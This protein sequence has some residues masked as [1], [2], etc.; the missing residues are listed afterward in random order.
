VS[1]TGRIPSM[2]R[3]LP[4]LLASVLVA[5][6]G[7][8][9]PVASPAPVPSGPAVVADLEFL[10]GT[11]QAEDGTME[12]WVRGG[13]CLWGVG[14]SAQGFEALL[15]DEKAGVPTYTA[16]PEG[17]TTADFTLTRRTA[18]SATFSNPAHDFPKEIEYVR[19]GETLVATVRGD[20]EAQSVTLRLMPPASAGELE[21]ADTMFAAETAERGSDGW[22]AWFDEGGA[23]FRPTGRI[24]GHEQIKAAMTKLLDSKGNR[25]DWQPRHSGLA[26]SGALG[27]TVGTATLILDGKDSGWHGSYVTIWKR[28]PDGRWLVLFDTGNNDAD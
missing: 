24:E 23:M 1:V 12:T 17:K 13:D 22:V 11:W 14:F 5:C 3:P 16:F 2:L 19:D 7:P 15:L 4:L 10:L 20:G 25:L 27:F 18:T 21:K 9:K 28:Q 6:G 26:A 8:S